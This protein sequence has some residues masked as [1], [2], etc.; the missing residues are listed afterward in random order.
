[1]KT[2]VECSLNSRTDTTFAHWQGGG[3]SSMKKPGF[4]HASAPG[5]GKKRIKP[6]LPDVGDS[7]VG[8]C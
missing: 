8:L 7:D 4:P 1:L 3:G 2:V 5:V 6:L